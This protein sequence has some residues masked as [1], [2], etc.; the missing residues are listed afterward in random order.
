MSQD[1][2]GKGALI[3][4]EALLF[5][6][7]CI[8]GISQCQFKSEET[9]MASEVFSTNATNTLLHKCTKNN[10]EIILTRICRI[11]NPL[12]NLLLCSYSVTM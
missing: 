12:F 2:G 6:S 5:L 4:L 7:C 3:L 10:L 9:W 8:V 1:S 11:G